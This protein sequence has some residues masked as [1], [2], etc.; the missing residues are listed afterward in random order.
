MKS[1]LRLL[2]TAVILFLIPNVIFGQE[3][4]KAPNLGVTSS[5]A[6]F[7]GTG[8]FNVTGAS[9]VTGDVG[10]YTGAFTGFP[11]GSLIGTKHVV[12][13]ASATAAADVLVA[14]SS[15]TQAGTN[16]S[17]GLGGQ[18][19]T[20]G[21][22]QTVDAS[23]LNGTLTLDAQNNPNALFIIRI[24]GAFA[25]AVNSNV[26][27]T[28]SASACNVYWQINGQFDL[29]DGSAFSGTIVATGAIQLFG[30]STLLGRALSTTGAISLAANTVTNPCSC[31]TYTTPTF[32]QVGPLCQNA[33]TPA[34]LPTSSTNTTPITGTW[35]PAFSTATVGTTKYTFTP[36]V[37]QCATTVTMD[38]V[39]TTQITPTFTQVGPLCQNATT[40][41][42]L[43]TSSTNTTPITGT[44]SPAF[45]TATVGTTKYTFTPAAGQCAGTATMDVVITTQITP[46]FTQIGPLCQ[47]SAA[48]VLLTTS[49]NGITGTWN[50]LTIN[51]A[52]VGSINYKF[53]PTGS[54]AV[55]V[56]MNIVIT[57]VPAA[58]K[59]C[60]TQ[61]TCIVSTGTIKVTAPVNGTGISYIVT[62]TKPVVAAVTNST[63]LFTGLTPGV[64]KVTTTKG[65]CVSAAT[66]LTVNAVPGAPAAP[67]AC[68]TVLPSCV[69]PTGTI[70]VTAPA[71]GSGISY[72]V[73][74]TNPV[75]AAVTNATGLF[76]GL[77]PGVYNVTTTN[78]GCVSAVTTLTVKAV[79]G[80]LA[81]PTACVTQPTCIV[82]TGTIKVTAPAK[83]SG[84][85]YTVTGTNPVVPAVTNATGLFTG[86]TPGVYNVTATN[87]LCVSAATTLTVKKIPGAPPAPK[88]TVTEQ[89]TCVVPTGTIKVTA[90]PN[91][92][93]ISYTVTGINPVVAAVTNATGS[94]TRLTP[95]VYNVTVTNGGCVSAATQLTVKAIPGAPP[96]PIGTCKDDYKLNVYPNPFTDH[97]CFELQFK[98]DAKVCLE[99]YN[100]KGIKVA[101]VF[102]E[103]VKACSYYRS[104]Y[105]PV[106]NSTGVVLYRLIID[107]QLV[108]NGKVIHK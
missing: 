41:A 80:A 38:V 101:T 94:F 10:T 71:N 14:Y 21:V 1:A 82:S 8:A 19:L 16:I 7:T 99:I 93:G 24:N 90:P 65:G 45:S 86:L 78:G 55:P 11:P 56:T 64:Y 3:A 42:S 51:T 92:Y 46:T 23:T 108:L 60:V 89:P 27:L 69:V 34:S 49:I 96:A 76:T 87:G 40:P 50:P 36:A 35:S 105:T 73:T 74:G 31:V 62:G 12:D 61:P 85:S 13:P 5:F 77:T 53:T 59:A 22:Y 44:W 20:P 104:E 32:T 107:K 2:L 47:N 30:T 15:L 81:A 18:Y 48:P 63:G 97:L 54:C 72:T 83:G 57:A 43:Q 106:N 66:T 26:L 67:T 98:K 28:G 68:V 58:P 100:N 6:L 25:E 84:I 29:A 39:I 9:V 33:S 52:A 4:P 91:G 95:G 102:S 75:V 88:A 79:T 37:G 17:V 103:D 70:K